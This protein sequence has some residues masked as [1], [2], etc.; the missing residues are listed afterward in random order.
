MKIFKSSLLFCLVFSISGCSHIVEKRIQKHKVAGKVLKTTEEEDLVDA[1]TAWETVSEAITGQ[2][3]TE[4]ELRNLARDI[5]KDKDA[6][7][8]LESIATALDPQKV[9]VKYSPATGKRYSADME[10]CPE[11]GVKLLPVQ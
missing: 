9:R 10:I 8:A 6:Q 1:V 3:M 4:D 7:S 2:E 5:R 11:T